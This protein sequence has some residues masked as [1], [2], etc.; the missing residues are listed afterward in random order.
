MKTKKSSWRDWWTAAF[1]W[2]GFYLIVFIVLAKGLRP[3]SIF[4]WIV[5]FCLSFWVSIVVYLLFTSECS[6]QEEC[7]PAR[8]K[9]AQKEL[10]EEIFL[11]REELKKAR[12]ELRKANER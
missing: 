7:N 8:L 5:V 1:L 4:W 10:E 6:E 12:M 2:F 3:Q 9:A 11:T